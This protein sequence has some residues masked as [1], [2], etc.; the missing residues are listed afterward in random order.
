MSGYDTMVTVEVLRGKAATLDQVIGTYTNSVT[1]LYQLTE[2]LNRMWDGGASQAFQT[3]FNF[4]KVQF[5]NGGITL[6]NYTQTLYDAAQA[7][8][9]ADNQAIN[10]INS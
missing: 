8:V 5:E 1:T 2:D 3:K 9:S 4:Q 6:R 10:I 7:Y